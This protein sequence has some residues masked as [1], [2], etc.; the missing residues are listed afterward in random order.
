M[1]GKQRLLVRF[2]GVRGSYPTPGAHTLRHGGNTSC[3]EVQAGEHTLIFD[4]GSGIIRLGDALMRRLAQDTTKQ[5]S[6]DL[7][8]FITHGHGDHLVGFPF[9]APLFEARTKLHLFGPDLAGQ[10]IEQLVTPLMSPPYFPVDMRQL[11]SQRTF[12]TLCD[13]Q[14]VAWRA[15]SPA[16][17]ESAEGNAG[18]EGEL[19]VVAK[20]TQCHPQNGA[21]IYRIEYAGKRIVYATDVEWK[22][23]SDAEFVQFIEGADLLI[24]DAQYTVTDYQQEKHG[25]GHSTIAMATEAARLAQVRELVLFHH[26]P[27]YDDNQLDLMEA[28]AR[29]QFAHTRSA[30]EGMEIDL[31][32]ETQKER[33]SEKSL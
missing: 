33:T 14:C 10:N 12:H 11:P 30:C 20:L 15:G 28:E 31:L 3:I 13:T 23:G 16:L 32:S 6:L 8:L 7:A 2:W 24:H 19:R 1:A 17:E 25:F 27:T 22:E 9:F 26:E 5:E 21:C 29:A 4:A 18:A